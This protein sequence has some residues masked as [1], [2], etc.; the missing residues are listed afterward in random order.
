MNDVLDIQN[1]SKDEEIKHMI[2]RTS[3]WF[4]GRG[5][6]TFKSTLYRRIEN[7]KKK[8]QWNNLTSKKPFTYNNKLKNITTK[9]TPSEARKNE[10]K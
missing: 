5:V 2:G 7:S 1:Y 6:K 3:A 8:K 10:N 9:H 4:A